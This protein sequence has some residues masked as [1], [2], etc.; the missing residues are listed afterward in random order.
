VLLDLFISILYAHV[1]AGFSRRAR[2][3]SIFPSRGLAAHHRITGTLDHVALVELPLELRDPIP[4]ECD[5]ER[6]TRPGSIEAHRR[7]SSL[8][9]RRW[10]KTDSNPRSLSEGKC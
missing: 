5:G 8:L 1:E 6:E 10:R 7:N 2:R 4:W 3:P 9:T